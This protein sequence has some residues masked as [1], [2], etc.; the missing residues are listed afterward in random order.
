MITYTTL[1]TRIEGDE[2][3]VF[4]EFSNGDINSVKFPLTTTVLEIQ[5]WAIDRAKWF[6]ER[7][8]EIQK[9]AEEALN[10]NNEEVWQS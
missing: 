5:Q 4:F 10:L 1:N 6:E 3:I 9:L 2:I 7:E 8:V